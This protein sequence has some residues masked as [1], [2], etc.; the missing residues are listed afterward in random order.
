MELIVPVYRPYSFAERETTKETQEQRLICHLRKARVPDGNW[1]YPRNLPERRDWLNNRNVD[2]N[3]VHPGIT[4]M[5]PHRTTPVPQATH[6]WPHYR[7]FPIESLILHFPTDCSYS[8]CHASLQR[9]KGKGLRFEGMLRGWELA[10]IPFCSCIQF[11]CFSVFVPVF[12]L[13]Y[14]SYLYVYWSLQLP[15]LQVFVPA[16]PSLL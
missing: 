4:G 14:I 7:Q 10:L 11:F 2:N 13:S 6:P 12:R 9:D 15:A 8:T 1:N 3:P 16:S 5:W